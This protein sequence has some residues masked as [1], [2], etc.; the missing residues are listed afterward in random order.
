M[1]DQPRVEITKDSL[2]SALKEQFESFQARDLGVEREILGQ[3]KKT[4]AALQITV[5][6][7]LRRVGKSTL[8][9]QIANKYLKDG[10]YF[11]NFRL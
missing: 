9:A 8:L 1:A 2:A 3:L 10:Y 11:V 7:G 6:T 4:I 5:V